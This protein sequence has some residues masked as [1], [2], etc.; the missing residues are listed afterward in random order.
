MRMSATRTAGKLADALAAWAGRLRPDA[1]DQEL[2]RRSLLDT[3]AVAV[4]ARQEPV[5]QAARGL[6][7]P[8]AGPPPRTPSTTTWT[9]P[10]PHVSAWS[11]HLPRLPPVVAPKPTCLELE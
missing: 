1:K 11:A 4:A 8:P 5:A 3:V 7:K 2:A 9:W 10:P 6:S